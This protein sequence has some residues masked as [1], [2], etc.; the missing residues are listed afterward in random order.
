VWI[1][2]IVNVKVDDKGNTNVGLGPGG[3]FKISGKGELAPLEVL[4]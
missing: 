3:L 4:H 1:P 2:G